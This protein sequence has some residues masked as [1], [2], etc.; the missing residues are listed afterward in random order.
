LWRYDERTDENAARERSLRRLAATS[1]E[2]DDGDT[3]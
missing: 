1:H 2:S 3:N